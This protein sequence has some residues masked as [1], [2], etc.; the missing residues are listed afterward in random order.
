M[1]ILE[2]RF[3][4]TTRGLYQ[5]PYLCCRRSRSITIH[6]KIAVDRAY[7]EPHQLGRQAITIV[8]FTVIARSKTVILGRQ[9][10][11]TVPAPSTAQEGYWY[12]PRVPACKPR[13]GVMQ[14]K[15]I[16]TYKL[17]SRKR[18]Y[19]TMFGIVMSWCI[20]GRTLS[21]KKY[22]FNTIVFRKD[23]F[24]IILKVIICSL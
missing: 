7:R 20:V 19:S 8:S 6:A 11:Y 10:I 2:Y 18:W 9:P 24:G 15:Y 13:E 22:K 1:M 17:G 3:I 12:Y 16:H 4:S 23:K 5:F 21:K 14:Y